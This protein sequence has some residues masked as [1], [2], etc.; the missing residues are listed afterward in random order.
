MASA[1]LEL[2]GTWSSAK[3]SSSISLAAPMLSDGGP[4]GLAEEEEGKPGPLGVAAVREGASDIGYPASL[5]AAIVG[6][7]Y[8][9][10][11]SVSEDFAEID[12]ASLPF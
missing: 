3:P 2:L 6:D 9:F 11:S 1:R 5:E 7:I 8:D 10:V 12:T 4:R